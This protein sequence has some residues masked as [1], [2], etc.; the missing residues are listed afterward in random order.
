VAVMNAYCQHLGGHIGVGGSVV[1]DEVKCPWH[2]WQWRADGTNFADSVFEGGLQE[3]GPH[4]DIS[5]RRVVR[6]G[7]HVVR[8][9]DAAEPTWSLPEVPE[10]ETGDYYPFTRTAAALR[11]TG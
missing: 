6:H 10:L 7:A 5:G 1:G 2:A 4:P 11:S 9:R 3:V 8:P